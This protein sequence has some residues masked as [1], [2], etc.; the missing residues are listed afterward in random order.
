M[1]YSCEGV[2]V[3]LT[4]PSSGKQLVS[5]PVHQLL[6]SH[7]RLDRQWSTYNTVTL[8]PSDRFY[9]LLT[10]GILSKTRNSFTPPKVQSNN[11]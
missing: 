6:T 9:Q 8:N 5:T 3:I 11:T 2:Q 1:S 10:S 7:P 4:H